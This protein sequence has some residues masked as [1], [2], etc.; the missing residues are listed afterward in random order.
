MENKKITIENVAKLKDAYDRL[1]VAQRRASDSLNAAKDYQ[2]NDIEIERDGNK[3]VVK[4]RALWEEIYHSAPSNAREVLSGKYPEAFKLAEEANAIKQE[5]VELS[6]TEFGFNP[7]KM[8]L[9][10]LFNLVEMFVEF[11]LSQKSND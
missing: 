5:V 7:D 1:E 9:I 6:A 2:E 8:R 3:F 10:D 11:K 4:E